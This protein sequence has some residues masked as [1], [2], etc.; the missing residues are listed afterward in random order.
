MTRIRPIKGISTINCH[1]PLRSMSCSRRATTAMFGRNTPRENK[2]E[3]T[4][5]TTEAA[6]EAR[7]TNSIHHHISGRDARP[8]KSAYLEKQVLIDSVKVIFFSL[9]RGTV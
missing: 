7:N 5:P 8:L 6:A 9:R 2:A 1:H 4:S 3:T